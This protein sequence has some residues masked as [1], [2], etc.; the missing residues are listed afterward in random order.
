MY[1]TLEGAEAYLGSP[2]RDQA[3]GAKQ[4]NLHKAE[5]YLDSLNWQGE[6]TDSAQDIAW[7][8]TGVYDSEGRAVPDDTIPDD[9]VTAY[10]E[11][12]GLDFEGGLYS[13]Q[14]AAVTSKSVTAGSVSVSKEYLTSQ[15]Q[16][17]THGQYVEMLIGQYLEQFDEYHLLRA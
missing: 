14:E 9:V 4:K 13:T 5:Q 8:R 11:C 2:W 3:A 7:P 15:V 16:E 10:Y 1:G 12:A 17:P 6:L